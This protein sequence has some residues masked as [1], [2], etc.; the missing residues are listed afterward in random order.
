MSN[1]PAEGQ[2]AARR[3]QEHYQA[4]PPTKT[5]TPWVW[6]DHKL[7]ILKADYTVYKVYGLCIFSK[8]LNGLSSFREPRSAPQQGRLQTS[9]LHNC[10]VNYRPIVCQP[11]PYPTNRRPILPTAA[12]S[13]QP[14]PYPANHRP[15][16]PTAVLFCQISEPYSANR[17]HILPTKLPTAALSSQQSTG[18]PCS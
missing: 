3:S 16:L 18:E 13:C 9:N 8:Y 6:V 17:R 2:R 4:P 1:F 7:C 15:I 11:P 12:L 10:L 5:P 14:P